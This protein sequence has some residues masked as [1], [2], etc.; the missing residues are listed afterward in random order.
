MAARVSKKVVNN[1][2]AEE[3]QQAMQ[4]YATA[5]KKAA[6]LVA[7]MDV[8]VQK[9]RDKYDPQLEPLMKETEMNFET[10]QR[11]C[12][13]NK[14][15]MFEKKRSI[16][17]LHGIVGFRTGTPK[18]KLLPKMNWEKVLDNLK[19]YL[20]DYVRTITEPAKDRL[21]ADREL[22]DVAR[23]MYRVGIKVDQDEKFFV[24][25]KKEDTEL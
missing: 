10:I 25:L 19:H 4:A 14:E 13:E 1:V 17:T 12:E 3:F 15:T 24:E 7:K 6:V 20:P 21:L 16:E 5:N 23:N 11:H 18:L 9:I 2:T 8:E 22:E